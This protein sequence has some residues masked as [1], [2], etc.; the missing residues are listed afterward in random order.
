MRRSSNFS[1][2]LKSQ[3]IFVSVFHNLETSN[4]KIEKMIHKHLNFLF[5]IELVDIKNI[6]ILKYKII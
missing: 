2:D 3:N 5:N 1:S 6:F 4:G